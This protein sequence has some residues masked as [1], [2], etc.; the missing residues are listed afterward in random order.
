MVR[1]GTITSV[2]FT[3]R[4]SS[5]RDDRGEALTATPPRALAHALLFL[6][7]LLLYELTFS[8]VPTS[9]GER[10]VSAIDR[11]DYVT[12]LIANA[13]LAN[14]F[15]FSL[16]RF[17]GALGLAVPTLPMMQAVNAVV[18]AV[19]ATLFAVAVGRL[20]GST[21]LGLVGGALLATSFGYWYFANGELH[22]LSLGVLIFIF[23]LLLSRRVRGSAYGYGFVVGVALLNAVATLLHQENFV[24][25]FTALALLA[26][27]K[28]WRRS[29]RECLVYA[30]AGSVG[31]WLL[32][33]TV[34]RFLL[35]IPTLRG[36][37]D[38]YVWIA[39]YEQRAPAYVRGSPP[40]ILAK[41]VKGQLTAVLFGTQV[42]PDL[43]KTPRLLRDPT[44]DVLLALTLVG[45]ALMLFLLV[46]LWRTRRDLWM[47]WRVPLVACAVWFFS[48]KILI[49]WWYWPTSTEYH[50]VTLPPLVLLLLLGAIAAQRGVA[51][52]HRPMRA[53]A[54]L[55]VVVF[56]VNVWGGILPWYRYGRMKDA[57]AAQ[58]R[59]AFRPD[60]VF[61][62]TESGVDAI[63]SGN[64]N[65]LQVNALFRT[66]T[67]QDVF[68]T[69]RTAI[70][71]ELARGHRVFVY[72]F[73][74][75]PYTLRQMN[76]VVRARERELSAAEFA[77]FL[78]EL[79]RQ[80]AMTPVLSYW[81]ESKEPLYLFGRERETL[82]QLTRKGDR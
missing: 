22:L 41:V 5:S 28:P 11:A 58:F 54:A 40:I 3:E 35:G 42:I 50:V 32:V 10:F 43:A 36:V 45:Y 18:A 56:V 61:I 79:G 20:G 65:G 67:R 8:S 26:V 48:Y 53:A 60:D 72:N 57:L 64:G 49:H 55:L 33:L 77:E 37:L 4:P 81:E 1:E 39:H 34:G 80:Y 7:V 38:W 12:M 62:S 73:V 47:R 66:S 63:F 21:T 25:G 29:L 69:I 51:A 19:G 44:A 78:A 9:D 27:G 6:A 15:S 13:P 17:L 2:L 82:W 70:A 68:D 23:V 16:K 46:E 71:T 59:A 24:F 31:T 52:R 30:I 76:E 75:S 74:P 14:Y